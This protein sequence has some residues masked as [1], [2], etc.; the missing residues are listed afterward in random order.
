MVRGVDWTSKPDFGG[1]ERR[2]RSRARQRESVAGSLDQARALRCGSGRDSSGEVGGKMGGNTRDDG[3]WSDG[4][5]VCFDG[6]DQAVAGGFESKGA[7]G[8]E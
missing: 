6:V 3:A 4:G 7:I 5:Q 2:R 1:V 8:D